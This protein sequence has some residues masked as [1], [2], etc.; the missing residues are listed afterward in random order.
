[1][2]QSKFLIA[3]IKRGADLANMNRTEFLTPEHVLFGL[4]AQGA[5]RH[6]CQQCGADERAII[7][8]LM[9]YISGMDRVPDDTT[10]TVLISRQLQQSLTQ[11]DEYASREHAKEVSVP[12]FI[13]AVM[14]LPDSHA[15]TVIENN[16]AYGKDELVAYS[17]QIYAMEEEFDGMLDED[18]GPV[19]DLSDESVAENVRNSIRLLNNEVGEN[20]PIVG[21]KD[22]LERMTHVLC[23]LLKNGVLVVG[24]HGVGK[25]T[26]VRGLVQNIVKENVPK[27]LIGSRVWEM[28]VAKL[29]AGT[30][31]K[32]EFE[33][34]LKMIMEQLSAAKDSILF[35]DDIH[36]VLGIGASDGGMDGAQMLEPYLSGS[37]LRVI[38]CTT[39]ADMNRV[40]A[41]H[42]GLLAQ[43]Q[44]IDL[45]EMTKDETLDV[46]KGICPIMSKE[47]E[48]TF[49]DGVL[50]HIVDLSS[51]Y[52]K[53]HPQPD[54]AIDLMDEAAA[55]L[56]VHPKKS[57][58]QQVA[59]DTVDEV[60]A[61]MCK[62]DL[63]TLSA[64][65][66]ARLN[67]LGE[68]IRAK[69]YGQDEAVTTVVQAVEQS[70]AGLGDEEKPMASLLFVGPTGVGKTEV[71]RVLAD[72]LGFNLVRFDMSEYT[73]KH[74]V[75]K[76]IGSPAGYI[77][78]ED[79]GLLT[80]AI[81]K[82]P[83]CVL[84]LDEIEKAHSDIYNI[85][86]QVMDYGTLTDNR[87]NKAL[88]NN[89]ILVMTSNAG[90]QHAGQAGVGFS[91]T[92][93][94]GGAMLASVKKL[95]RPEFLN[96][97]SGTVVFR[98]MDEHMADLILNKKLDELQKKLTAKKVKLELTPEARKLLL[99]K[100]Y[101]RQYG[102]REMDRVLQQLLTPVLTHEILYGRLRDGG[103][104]TITPELLNNK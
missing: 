42:Q 82:T 40:F 62:I 12:H 17:E 96:R 51:R 7:D 27:K 30:S 45:K 99:E 81:R 79:G 8:N 33:R 88:F 102:A 14:Q 50:E 78:Y 70:R 68:R 57:E 31:Y 1:M 83:N 80:E 47:H 29:L 16:I 22:E 3:A 76:L 19:D 25:T 5:F 77:G 23:R 44:Q 21:R 41:K 91:S 56:Q 94:K 59:N 71:C 87:G 35:I 98:E 28:N 64:E 66:S 69:I 32:G 11:A 36:N 26:L 43:F 52:I 101:S 61:K 73:E 49:N 20:V 89:V 34:Q 95:F 93:T 6:I 84:L 48:V 4:M 63:L 53:G 90:A 100:G 54:K 67:T 75:A 38:G 24:D 60:V 9:R 85:L 13:N 15:R 72:E 104:I 58:L 74:N 65:K 97:L 92:V 103:T 10:Y 46:L 39:Y 86:L 18:D 2:Q 37:D 55:W